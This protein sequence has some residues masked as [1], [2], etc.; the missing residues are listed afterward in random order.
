MYW[1]PICSLYEMDEPT[2]N[3]YLSHS[4]TAK[5]YLSEHLS[6]TQDLFI[7]IKTKKMHCNYL[8][9]SLIPQVGKKTTAG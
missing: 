2:Q 7:N 9:L 1:L 8:T 6:S 4:F 5:D 3:N